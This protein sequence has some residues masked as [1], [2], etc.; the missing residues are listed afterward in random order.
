MK[1]KE[2]E[3]SKEKRRKEKEE[4]KNLYINNMLSLVLVIWNRKRILGTGAFFFI[5]SQTPLKCSYPILTFLLS[6]F[7]LFSLSFSS[8]SKRG[9]STVFRFQ[10]RKKPIFNSPLG[11][12]K[13]KA[14]EICVWCVVS[15]FI[16]L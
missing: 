11:W 3:E 1:D 13:K 4:R 8:L 15:Y 10:N 14:L 5:S 6:L 12:L 2:T 7:S 16:N 9:E